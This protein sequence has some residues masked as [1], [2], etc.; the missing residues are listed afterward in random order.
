MRQDAFPS[1]VA[2]PEPVGDP[3]ELGS[4]GLGH[5]P[6]TLD[7]QRP[8]LGAAQVLPSR[9]RMSANDPHGPPFL[10]CHCLFPRCAS[11]AV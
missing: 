2:P 1:L 10:I 4:Q 5:A 7:Q 8:G 3:S 11:R 9:A 6:A